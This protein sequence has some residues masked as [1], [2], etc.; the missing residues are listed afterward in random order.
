[1]M[2]AARTIDKVIA[3]GRV[4]LAPPYFRIITQSMAELKEILAPVRIAGTRTA[5]DDIAAAQ[6]E[7]EAEFGGP[8]GIPVQTDPVPYTWRNGN[9]DRE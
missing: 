2:T 9:G 8:L 5:E 4:H 7:I 6:A 3:D 1:M